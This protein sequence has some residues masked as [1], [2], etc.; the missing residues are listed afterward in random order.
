MLPARLWGRVVICDR[1]ILDAAV[2]LSFRLGE[3]PDRWLCWRLLK[4]MA[5]DPRLHVLFDA[6]ADET[7]RRKD[8]ELDRGAIEERRRRYRKL[9]S[10]AVEVI[11]TERDPD[12]VAEQVALRVYGLLTHG[13]R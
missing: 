2:D 9:R 11:D 6:S 5:P 13:D 4:R 10:P 7:L 1:Y 12:V 8:L 3:D